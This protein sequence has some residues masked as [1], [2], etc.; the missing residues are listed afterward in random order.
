MTDI[1]TVTIIGRLVRDGELKY[2]NG[3]LAIL[4]LSVA[5]NR[6]VKKGDEWIDEA[7][8]F[9]AS[10]FGKG[11]EAVSQYCEKGKQIAISGS[12]VQER[13][14]TTDRQ[15][16]SRVK[17]NADSV[18][19]LGGKSDTNKQDPPQEKLAAEPAPD[20]EDDIPF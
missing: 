17:I 5:V 19:L 11:A 6:R 4:N 2:T 12:L 14:E 9:D 18:Q 10:F 1:N 8:F 7:S 16:R 3:G 20:F 15:K 13:W